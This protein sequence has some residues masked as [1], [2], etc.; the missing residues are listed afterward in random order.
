MKENPFPKLLGARSES[1]VTNKASADYSSHPPLTGNNR[2]NPTSSLPKA[3]FT[4]EM[5][6]LAFLTGVS[7]PSEDTA[8]GYRGPLKYLSPY[9]QYNWKERAWRSLQTENMQIRIG[10]KAEAAFVSM[11]SRPFLT[12]KAVA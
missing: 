2:R 8:E 3:S 11:V 12:S 6:D 1:E 9:P 5:A 7:D 4:L 10:K